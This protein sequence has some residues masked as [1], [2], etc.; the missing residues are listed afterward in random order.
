[1][2]VELVLSWDKSSTIRIRPG[3][4]EQA[5]GSMSLTSRVSTPM[6]TQVSALTSECG[7]HREA[8]RSPQDEVDQKQMPR[9]IRL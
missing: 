5:A 1:M 3:R 7:R 8:N 2:S 9:K 4:E 6:A